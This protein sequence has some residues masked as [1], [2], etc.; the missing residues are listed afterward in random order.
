MDVGHIHLMQA[1][2]ILV[3]ACGRGVIAGGGSGHHAF[4]GVDETLA[5]GS[6]VRAPFDSNV[7]VCAAG[8][9]GGGCVEGEGDE[10]CWGRGHVVFPGFEVGLRQV[11]ERGEGGGGEVWC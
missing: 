11:C 4:Y 8:G 3:S 1:G 7:G 9:G 10:G 5:R 2:E 6:R